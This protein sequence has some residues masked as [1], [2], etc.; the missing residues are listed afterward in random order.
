MTAADFRARARELLRGRWGML[1]PLALLA[2][3]FASAFFIDIVYQVFFS[4][5]YPL[6]ISAY[7]LT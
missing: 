3:L 4:Q 1:M 5:P 7:G 6:P 2:Q